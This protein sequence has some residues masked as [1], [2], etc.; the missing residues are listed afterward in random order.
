MTI[1]ADKTDRPVLQIKMTRKVRIESF[2]IRQSSR[3]AYCTVQYCICQLYVPLITVF[4]SLPMHYR[5]VL[6]LRIIIDLLLGVICIA[7]LYSDGTVDL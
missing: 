4:E 2:L 6:L 1:I 7:V 3:H 5:E